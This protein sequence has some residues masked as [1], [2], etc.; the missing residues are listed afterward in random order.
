MVADIFSNTL[1][2]FVEEG[3]LLDQIDGVL[4]NLPQEN[5]E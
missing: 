2:L 1:S 3:I 4:E 5:E